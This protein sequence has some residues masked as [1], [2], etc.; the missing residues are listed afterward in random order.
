MH[1]LSTHVGA[2]IERKYSLKSFGVPVE[3]I[4]LT[5]TGNIKTTYLKQWMKVRKIVELM[6]MTEG[7]EG[8]SIPVV[9]CPGL[10]DVVF[11]SGT[12]LSCHPGNVR[13][14]YMVES[15]HENQA[16]VRQTTQTELAEQLITEVEALGGR[17]LKWDNR[18]YWT[19]LTD[20]MQI[21]TKVALCIRD[22]KYKT[23]AQ[24]SRQSNESYTYL[25]QGQQDGNKRRR[26][27][28][29]GSLDTKFSGITSTC[30]R[31][32]I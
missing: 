32:W 17:F 3:L 29:D 27:N 10:N 26:T 11:R 2:D 1:H 28:N 14:R 5:D 6:R 8:N 13:F 30:C 25:F 19:E 22:F 21:N 16:V 31:S 15:K 18:G 7:G 9:E 4:P 12:S 20:R 24:Q 23:K